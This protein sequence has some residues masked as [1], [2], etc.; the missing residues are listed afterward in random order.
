M[1]YLR[2]SAISHVIEQLQG[3]QAALARAVG[4]KPQAVNQRVK[5]RRPVPPHHCRAIE[6]ATGGRVAVHDLRPD[7]FGEAPAEPVSGAAA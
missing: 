1:L 2:M 3:G 6:T 4:V 7:V 5:G